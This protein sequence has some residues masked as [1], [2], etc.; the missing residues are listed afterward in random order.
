VIIF[1]IL[2]LF[3]GSSDFAFSSWV[4][5]PRDFAPAIAGSA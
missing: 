2:T 3:A 4:P 5:E 1:W